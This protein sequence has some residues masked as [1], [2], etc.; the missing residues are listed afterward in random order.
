M[1]DVMSLW[2][3]KTKMFIVNIPYILCFYE[4]VRV[5]NVYVYFPQGDKRKASLSF[6]EIDFRKDKNQRMTK[7][8]LFL[9]YINY[10]FNYH[11]E[12]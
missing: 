3:Y 7:S 1:P 12:Y 11:A 2:A 9:N 8:F 5:K 10:I 6:L 4:L